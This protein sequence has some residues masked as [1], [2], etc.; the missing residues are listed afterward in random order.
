MRKSLLKL[1]RAPESGDSLLLY[2]FESRNSLQDGEGDVVDGIL[3]SHGSK[4]AYPII[5][6]IPVMLE[7]SF[8][9]EFLSKHSEKICQ[10]ETLSRV[11]LQ[12]YKKPV[13]SFSNEW[14]YHFDADLG[15]TW[16]WTVEERIEQFLMEVDL[17]RSEVKDK[18]ILDAGC[19]NGQLSEGLS[20]LGGTV[21]AFDYSTSVFTA[22][23]RRKSPTVHFV[24]GD[25]QAPPF[26]ANTFDI[27]ISNGVIH[28]TPDTYRTFTEVAK[29]AKPEGRFY[30][31]LY[32]KPEKF[33]RRYGIYSTFEL[34]RMAVSRLPDPC[35]GPIVRLYAFSLMML[36]T[37]LGKRKDRS[38][39]ERVVAAYDSLTPRWRHYHTPIELSY[40]FF[41]N[42]YSRQTLSHWD[43]AYGFG[44]VAIK[45]AQ[46]ATPG[47][48]FGKDSVVKRYWQ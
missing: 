2:I 12:R 30:L 15:K 13:W 14:D 11:N 42:G 20:A 4:K 46:S 16:G 48:N 9:E 34:M 31:W 7:D 23:R 27:I 29:L 43:N 37:L 1:L 3:F 44:M 39:H 32:R 24:R 10:D 45:R 18:L 36:H 47:M 40:W 6:G 33:F 19:G 21:V 41:L 5:D 35:Q 8:T 38:W 25:L 26:N 17:D 28:H 22:E